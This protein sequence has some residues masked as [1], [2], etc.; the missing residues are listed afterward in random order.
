MADV[1]TLS[2]SAQALFCAIADGVGKNNITKVLSLTKYPTYT[3][4]TAGGWNNKTNR[5]RIDEASKYVTANVSIDEVEAFLLKDKTWYIS[6]V[7]IAKTLIESLHK[8]VD[9]D[10]KSLSAKGF[11]T[12]SKSMYYF[13]GDEKVMGTIQE[14]FKVAN[15]KN[16]DLG[17]TKFGDL[18]KW[19]PA[20]IYYANRGVQAKLDNQLKLANNPKVLYTFVD[21]NLFIA[22]EIDQGNLL[23]LSLKKQIK[24]VTIEPVNFDI[25]AKDKIID[26]APKKSGQ[27]DG[28]LWYKGK[29]GIS[30]W[31]K[32]EPLKRK[33]T[34]PF[35]PLT[36][37]INKDAPA[38]DIVIKISSGQSRTDEKGKI[39]MRHDASTNS[40]KVDFSYKSAQA[41]GGSIVSAKT[42]ADLL[43][44]VNMGLG[45]KFLA[46][47]KAGVSEYKQL[48]SGG[49][50]FKID[51]GNGL[52]NFDFL[53]G[54]KGLKAH[55]KQIES[56]WQREIKNRTSIFGPKSKT[57]PYTNLRGEAAAMSVMNRVGPILNDWLKSQS[58]NAIP[59]GMTSN[60]I[61][62]FI[63]ILFRYVTS[64]SE[65]S[66]QFVIAK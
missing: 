62:K 28:G 59:D 36:S 29:S 31:T 63:R 39:Q 51:T 27:V 49:M 47:F 46:E 48:L 57:N 38:R 34:S 58:A 26:G 40:W 11:L 30:L 52:T 41:R 15:K 60:E 20:D 6:S 53:L 19:S 33:H 13:R 42:F 66:A 32:Y 50:D 54:L 17:I 43:D 22:N 44:Q 61:D 2:E 8:V 18:N 7:Q 14:C 64:Q 45:E 1:T 5:K 55:R 3:D 24:S 12:G 4:F 21:L 10:F 16:G 65:S 23:P 56:D 25:A 9:K 37:Q 35:E